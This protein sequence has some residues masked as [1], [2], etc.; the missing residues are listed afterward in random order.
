MQLF[1]LLHKKALPEK[2]QGRAVC[3]V[4]L[5]PMKQVSLK[6]HQLKRNQSQGL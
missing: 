6:L 4:C 2:L 5:I 1:S 3:G